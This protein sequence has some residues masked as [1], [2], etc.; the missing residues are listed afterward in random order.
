MRKP[1]AT[2]EIVPM[3]NIRGRKEATMSKYVRL[4]DQVSDL[5]VQ[6]QA[7]AKQG[8]NAVL[9]GAL[10]LVL[11]LAVLIFFL[12]FEQ[13]VACPLVS[14]IIAGAILGIGVM[15][16][17]QGKSKVKGLD[18]RIKGVRA[19]LASL[20][21]QRADLLSRIKA[22]DLAA[23]ESFADYVFQKLPIS[24]S[25][26]QEALRFRPQRGETCFA[27]VTDVPLGRVKSRTVTRKVGG[28]YRIGK[29]YVPVQKKRV[30][31]VEM[32]TLDV[33]TLAVTDR[34]ILYLGTER[35]LTT[36]LDRIL[37]LAAYQDALSVTKE[38]RQSSDF[39]LKVDGE[40]LV[41][42]LEGID[43]LAN[44]GQS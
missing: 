43:Q 10:G 34:R 22:G 37:E 26:L 25:P 11:S 31:T 32:N 17:K 5:A 20:E 24:L 7:A 9:F 27:Q 44:E 41:A 15:R 21:D 2:Q 3:A 6:K 16:K 18:E 38:G 36:K 23:L 28:G 35:K 19:N 13:G 29:I 39:F 1:V 12:A 4:H 40:L 42:I 30:Q 8:S 14:V 33:G